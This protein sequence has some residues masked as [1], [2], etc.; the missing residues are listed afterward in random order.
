MIDIPSFHNTEVSYEY[1][2]ISTKRNPHPVSC[3]SPAGHMIFAATGNMIIGIS[4]LTGDHKEQLELA[5]HHKIGGVVVSGNLV[6]VSVQDTLMVFI[7]CVNESSLEVLCTL[8]CT[9]TVLSA[10]KS[11]LIN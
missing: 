9:N 6:F 1:I 4:S 2:S 5:A 3:L 10:L 11:R 8:D 7:C